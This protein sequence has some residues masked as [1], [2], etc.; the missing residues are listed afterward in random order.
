MSFARKIGQIH[1]SNR[2]LSKIFIPLQF[3]QTLH[4]EANYRTKLAQNCIK[5]RI[6]AKKNS[7]LDSFAAAFR[8]W[9][10]ASFL[11]FNPSIAS[12]VWCLGGVYF[13]W[14]AVLVE[15]QRS[16]T[17]FGVDGLKFKPNALTVALC[18][19]MNISKFA[20]PLAVGADIS[21]LLSVSMVS[22]LLLVIGV[23][24]KGQILRCP[25]LLLKSRDYFPCTTAYIPK[26]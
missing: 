12:M 26:S 6:I 15:L 16:L 19:L 24:H 20:K 4:K 22:E 11:D 18:C 8:S 13:W 1:F 14:S 21:S 23:R 17:L 2:F 25:V 9:C 7:P 5:Y 10:L 3:R